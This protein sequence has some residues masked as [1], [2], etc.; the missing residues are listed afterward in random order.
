MNARPVCRSSRRVN[1]SVCIPNLTQRSKPLIVFLGKQDHPV[2]ISAAAHF[3]L[4]SLVQYR[5]LET[6]W[7]PYENH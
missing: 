4:E 5:K 3:S 6:L 1:N 7:T 2:K